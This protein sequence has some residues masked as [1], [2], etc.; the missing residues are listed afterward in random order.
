MLKK[1]SCFDCFLFKNAR[2]YPEKHC[3]HQIGPCVSPDRT[4]RKPDALIVTKHP[5]QE[6]HVCWLEEEIKKDKEVV[7]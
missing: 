7:I 6:K 3:F 5:V 2:S 4:F 1:C